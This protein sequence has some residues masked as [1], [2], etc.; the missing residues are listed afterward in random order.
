MLWR[1]GKWAALLAVA[2]LIL[3]AL[4]P[5]CGKQQG[6]TAS[7]PKR[8]RLAGIV[9]QEDQFF[10]LVELGMQDA[11]NKA[12]AE[13]LKA[14][15]DNKLDKEIQ[16]VNTYVGQKVD[17]I[18]ISPLD[19]KG[20]VAALKQARDK[21]VVVICENTPIDGDVSQA[22]V[23]CNAYNLGM[24]TGKAAHKYIQEKLG[25]R[26]NIALV[27]FRSLLA[28]QSD[29][30]TNG[31]K[32]QIKDLPG[33][34]IV[35]EQD[36]WLPEA[37]V[38]RV[39]DILTAH[40]EVNLIWSAN[41]GGTIGS[42]LAVKNAGK[43]GKIAVFGTDSSEQLVDFLLSPDNILQATTSQKPVQAGEMAVEFA[44]KTLKHE[45]IPQ[46]TVSMEG[47]LLSRDEPEKVKAFGTQLKDWIAR[48]SR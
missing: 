38:K 17:A 4:A 44:M 14:N 19:R 39:T 8:A 9:F 35:A 26:A 40:P 27:E 22:Y 29:D 28:T 24:Q 42:V 18:V 36:A 48:S 47:I 12:G 25:G 46:K 31:F 6:T 11:A 7:A 2:A 41:E 13:L 32:D 21:G 33:V 45:P 30:R 23:E 5:G 20:S 10:R 34:K 1:T 3:A 37:A 15:S 16:L 43:A